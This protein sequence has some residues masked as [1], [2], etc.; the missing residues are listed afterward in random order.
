M[1]PSCRPSPSTSRP[2]ARMRRPKVSR[3]T[4]TENTVPA[5]NKV[6]NKQAP[7]F[8]KG[9]SALFSGHQYPL[10]GFLL[11][12]HHFSKALLW[13]SFTFV[14]LSLLNDVC[15]VCFRVL[16]RKDC[17]FSQH[18]WEKTTATFALPKWSWTHHLNAQTNKRRR[19]N[20]FLTP[21]LKCYLHILHLNALLNADTCTETLIPVLIYLLEGIVY[22]QL[23]S[24]DACTSRCYLYHPYHR[25]HW[26]TPTNIVPDWYR[27][28]S[29]LTLLQHS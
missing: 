27:E 9:L 24:W 6:L 11:I 5:K 8:F 23:L 14:L 29:D 3:W 10:T 1:L 20:C 13:P 25:Y 2:K 28:A 22:K 21:T 15:L 17:C 19:G 26:P 16:K 4:P 7:A 18:C 12:N